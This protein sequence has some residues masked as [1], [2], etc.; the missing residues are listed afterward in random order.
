M[1]QVNINLKPTENKDYHIVLTN[2][3]IVVQDTHISP[4]ELKDYMSDKLSEEELKGV[5]KTIRLFGISSLN[6]KLK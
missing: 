1:K 6:F 3:N 2:D 5:R 4:T